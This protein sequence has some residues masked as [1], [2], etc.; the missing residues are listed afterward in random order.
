[1]MTSKMSNGGFQINLQLLTKKTNYLTW[2]RSI[3]AV[4]KSKNEIYVQGTKGKKHFAVALRKKNMNQKSTTLIT[5][6]EL[7]FQTY[8]GKCEN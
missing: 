4:F 6:G 8:M 1:M 2:E 3:C 5:V 7:L